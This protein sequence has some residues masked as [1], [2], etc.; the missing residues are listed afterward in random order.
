M[1]AD[2]STISFSVWRFI[3]TSQNVSWE[4]ETKH[5]TKQTNERTNWLIEN[6]SF[7][8]V[9]FARPYFALLSASGMLWENVEW[10]LEKKKKTLQN[11]KPI[12]DRWSLVHT[13]RAALRAFTLNDLSVTHVVVR[14][15][16]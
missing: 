10:S 7:V 1:F 12:T 15:A 3:I 6:D 16:A 2:Q 13:L 5:K 14:R 9:M 4:N 8:F 11:L